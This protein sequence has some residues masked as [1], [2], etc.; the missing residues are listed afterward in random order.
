MLCRASRRLDVGPT[1]LDGSTA[2]RENPRSGPTTPKSIDPRVLRSI[3]PKRADAKGE[4]I[5]RARRPACRRRPDAGGASWAVI[6]RERSAGIA[7]AS[8]NPQV[9]TQEASCVADLAR[10]CVLPAAI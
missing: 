6:G 7:P 8:R 4:G 3:R 1:S 9:T 10:V 5:V 2:D